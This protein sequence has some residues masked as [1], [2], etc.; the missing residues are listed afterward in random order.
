MKTR[1]STRAKQQQ[2][3]AEAKFRA[4]MDRVKA[5][6]AAESMISP[7]DP[8]MRCEQFQSIVDQ[9]IDQ[10]KAVKRVRHSAIAAS[11][12]LARTDSFETWL[13]S[14]DN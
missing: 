6:V 10:R 8:I 14:L 2:A 7:K 13:D 9:S 5:E 1:S 4:F 11:N 12:K 3:M